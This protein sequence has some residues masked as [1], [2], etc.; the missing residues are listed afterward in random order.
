MPTGHY[1]IEDLLEVDFQSVAEFGRQTIREV[2]Q[3]DLEAH[4]EIM[5]EMVSDLADVDTD[6]QRIYGSSSNG[7][8]VE[9]DEH[10]R[11]PTQKETHGATVAFPLRLF[12]YSL[13][14]TEKWMR[15]N[16]PADMAQSTISA[17]KSHRRRVQDEIRRAIFE[18]SNYTFQDHLV[19][20]VDLD[21]K[22]LVNAD[23]A[24][25][26]DGPFGE[27]FDGSSHTHYLANASLTNAVAN[28]LVDHIVEHGHGQNVKIYINRADAT[29]WKGLSDFNE[30][31][32]PRMI[33]RASDVPDE[34]VDITQLDNKAIGI[35]NA[36]EVW[37]KP[38]IP[39]NYA[40]C[41]DIGGDSEPP[42]VFRQRDAESLQGL[43]TAA[44]IARFPLITEHMEAEFGLGV[45]NRTNG[46]VLQFNNSTYQDPSF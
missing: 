2:L 35:F 14:W 5:E 38:W 3:R 9:V 18:S 12:Q 32:D 8:M 29:A 24:P 33:F 44:E 26:P 4:N 10:G 16:T 46:A 1:T 21:V 42:L 13:G 19:D 22:R 20:N 41:I 23:G 7:D 34:R 36:A 28:S 45:W 30:Y 6:R 17:E 27:T 15:T 37:V 31:E 11:S 43:R 39:Q 40:L 25:I